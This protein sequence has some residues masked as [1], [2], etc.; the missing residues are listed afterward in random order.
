MARKRKPGG[1]RKPG[2]AAGPAV[3]FNTRIAPEIRRR[4]EQE[5]KRNKRSLSQEIEFRLKDSFDFPEW[6]Q[7][8]FGEN[9]HY[10]LA[11]LVARI[12]IGVESKTD[13]RC[14]WRKDPFT[15]KALRA[16]IDLILQRVIPEGPIEIPLAVKQSAK[17]L[18]GLWPPE[19]IA[20]YNTPEGVGASIALGLLTQ[21][22]TTDVP[23]IN[24]PSNVRYAD[25]YYVMPRMREYLDL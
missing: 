11:Y 7:K 18:A 4:L 16:G 8:Q 22:T 20:F 10:A 24:H 23:P 5:A 3:H 2:S 13:G 17:N 25:S 15:G 9:H 12:A 19:Q 1:G 6:V 14:C 21:L